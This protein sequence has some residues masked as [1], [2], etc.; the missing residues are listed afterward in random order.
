MTTKC[1]ELP[2]VEEACQPSFLIGKPSQHLCTKG[3]PLQVYPALLSFQAKDLS[4]NWKPANLRS[5]KTLLIVPG[6]IL[7]LLMALSY[8]LQDSH[9]QAVPRRIELTAKRFNF[10]PG[11][12]TLKKGEPVVIVIKSQDAGHGLRF[13]DL[14]IDMKVAKGQTSELPFTPD[15]AGD[16]TGHCAV[17]CGPG[18]GS[19]QLII[20]VKE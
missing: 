4:M 17:F 10:N 19:M 7:A 9:A 14:P 20:H 18:H 1:L 16:F 2:K 11:E 13:D 6:M 8:L 15:K 12:I 5:A 3:H